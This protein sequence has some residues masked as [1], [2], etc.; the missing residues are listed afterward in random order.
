MIS[1][2]GCF[3]ALPPSLDLSWWG[4]DEEDG[5]SHLWAVPFDKEENVVDVPLYPAAEPVPPLLILFNS[6]GELVP[7]LGDALLL[8]P[9]SGEMH[10]QTGPA[11][12]MH[13]PFSFRTVLR[14]LVLS[15]KSLSCFKFP[16]LVL[17]TPGRAALRLKPAVLVL[18]GVHSEL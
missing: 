4:R 11:T 7:F 1:C 12:C 15:Y 16:V 2:E 5:F 17:W 14:G 8:E 9:T 10:A 3:H 13:P 18:R 6:K